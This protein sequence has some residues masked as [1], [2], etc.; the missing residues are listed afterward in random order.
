LLKL[1]ALE[2]GES[3]KLRNP[4]REATQLSGV[5]NEIKMKQ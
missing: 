4:F 5:N 3:W 1:T 2:R